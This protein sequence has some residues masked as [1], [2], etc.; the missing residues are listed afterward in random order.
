MITTGGRREV[1]WYGTITECTHPITDPETTG[2]PIIGRDPRGT[3][4]GIIGGQGPNFI[5]TLAL[6]SRLAVR[7]GET[8]IE[9]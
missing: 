3:G 1:T 4:Q 5:G 6:G 9:M 8:S 7:L 2:H